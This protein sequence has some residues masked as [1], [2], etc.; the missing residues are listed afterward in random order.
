MKTK[1]LYIGMVLT[2]ALTFNSCDL[3]RLPLTDLPDNNYWSG[4]DIE[5]KAKMAL[6]PLY[7][8]NITNGV[9]YT[10]SDF[11]SYHG[12][13]FMEHLTDNAFD[14]RGENNAFYKITSGQL[15]NNNNFIAQYWKSAYSRIGKCNRFLEGIKSGEDFADRKRMIAEARF[16]RAT[17]Y[18]YLTSYFHDVPLVTTPLTGEEANNVKKETQ[19]N[20]LAWV[21]TELKEAAADLPRFKDISTRLQTGRTCIPWPYIYARS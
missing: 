6:T 1:I 21:E 15:V 16:L 12:M 17:Q 13:L 11:W 20:I 5:N 4:T 19:A 7:R 8:G 9:E 10:P 18:H 2:S 3:E 14:R